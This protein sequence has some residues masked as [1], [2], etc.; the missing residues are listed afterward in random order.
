MGLSDLDL[1]PTVGIAR[2]AAME[3]RERCVAN[4]DLEFEIQIQTTDTIESRGQF[5]NLSFKQVW[6]SRSG[7]SRA[8]VLHLSHHERGRS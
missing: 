2:S 5:S 6:T 4:P 1:D 8:P 7:K 3:S